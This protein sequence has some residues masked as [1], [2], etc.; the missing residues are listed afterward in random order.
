MS[1]FQK[2]NA[3]RKLLELSEHATIEEIKSNYR[4]L[5]QR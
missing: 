4:A 5:I 2:I 1:M 3:A